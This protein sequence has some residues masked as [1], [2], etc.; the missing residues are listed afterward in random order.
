LRD[1]KG[2]DL[3]ATVCIACKFEFRGICVRRDLFSPRLNDVA[4]LAGKGPLYPEWSGCDMGPN[5]FPDGI[6][7]TI[8]DNP[9]MDTK[10]CMAAK[11]VL[12]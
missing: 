7:L 10:V 12:N 4:L 2:L 3:F 1:V 6:V 11:D 5:V 8:E 9:R